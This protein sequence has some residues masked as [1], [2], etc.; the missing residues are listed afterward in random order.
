MAD[1]TVSRLGQVNQAGDA[2]ALFLK[3]FAGEVLTAFR[4]A[5]VFAE[6]TMLR[7]I[8]SGKSASFPATWKAT[9]SYH[10]P[11]QEINGQSLNHNERVIT[12]DDLL[13]ADIF[14]AQID[15]AMNH[16]DIRSEYSFQA[17]DALA[18]QYDK[19][20]A[21]LGYLAARAAATV[22]GG[23]GGGS[24]TDADAD[25]NGAS[26]ATSFFD[27]VQL[28][29]EKDVPERDRWGYL[30]PAQYYNL[31]ET[32]KLLNRDFGG[33]PGTYSDGTLFR[34]AGVGI[35]KTNNLPT[36]NITTGPA[37]YQGDFSNSVSLIQH[38]SAQGTVRLLDLALESEYLIKHQGTLMVAK[39]AVGHG[40]L[41]PESAV[42]IKTA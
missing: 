3:V 1:M 18:Q 12:I 4:T 10:T 5:T 37:A 13:I 27:A 21:Q 29:D 23:N 41:R 16:F 2:T 34:V 30:K 25:T 19:N 9:A 33:D 20:L 26:L 6:R 8:S 38:R 7:T 35:V 22:T 28:L 39:Y 40:I 17:G 31:V 24:V 15:E 14:I 11:G 32:D 42:E 36:T